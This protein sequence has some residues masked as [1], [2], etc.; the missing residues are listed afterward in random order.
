LR[1]RAFFASEK[2]KPGN[3]YRVRD[4]I[5]RAERDDDSMDVLLQSQ[6]TTASRRRNG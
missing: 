4:I 2:L 1:R 3:G 6:T 5:G